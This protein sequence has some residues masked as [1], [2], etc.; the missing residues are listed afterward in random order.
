M[1]LML[2]LYYTQNTHRNTLMSEYGLAQTYL[3][4]LHAILEALD[5]HPDGIG[6]VELFGIVQ[7]AISEQFSGREYS[8][9]ALEHH[10]RLLESAGAVDADQGVVVRIAP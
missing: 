7:E 3:T 2:H 6:A 9:E 4:C 8:W 1:L 10:V 5:K